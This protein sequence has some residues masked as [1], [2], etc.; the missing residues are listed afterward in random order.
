[1]LRCFQMGIRVADLEALSMG[2][3]F[4][5]ITEHAN[6]SYDYKELATQEDFDRW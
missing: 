2:M 3:V 5:M 1:M 6:D 4:D